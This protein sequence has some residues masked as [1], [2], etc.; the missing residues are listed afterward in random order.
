M[1]NAKKKQPEYNTENEL[2][3]HMNVNVN[4]LHSETLMSATFLLVCIFF[5]MM[6][7]K[8]TKKKIFIYIFEL[9]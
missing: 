6:E 3:L 1:Y 8:H 2:N 7:K 5:K 9:E 4:V